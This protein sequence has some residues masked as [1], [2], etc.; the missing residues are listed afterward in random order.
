MRTA[1]QTAATQTRHE[2]VALA[3]PAAVPPKSPEQSA[4]TDEM[5]EDFQAT[6]PDSYRFWETERVRF[7]D[8]D[9]LGHVNNSAISVYLEQARVAMLHGVGGFHAG[10]DW[11]IVIVRS[12][13]EY[14]A[15]LLY[16]ATVRV[17]IRILRFGNTSLTIAAAIFNGEICIATQ[18]AV[19]VT[20][21]A[22]QH[23]PT[24]LP[25]SL[26]ATLAAY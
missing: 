6:N 4:E 14:R 20:V 5:T 11:T 23:R 26:R 9:P 12:L 13:I 22:A 15:E 21:D 25:E 17:G 8:L 2:C 16:P 1:G 10:N 18:E 19:L 3:C 24:P 7:A